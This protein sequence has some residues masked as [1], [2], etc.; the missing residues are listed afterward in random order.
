MNA[1][2]LDNEHLE[3]TTTGNSTPVVDFG[4]ER[5]EPSQLIAPV[6][7]ELAAGFGNT[8]IP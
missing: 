4:S 1:Q 8:V 5:C 2:V 7:N 6:L 3:S